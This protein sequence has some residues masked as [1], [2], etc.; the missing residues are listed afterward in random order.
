MGYLCYC[1]ASHIASLQQFGP[2]VLKTNF[3]NMYYENRSLIN[4]YLNCN[5]IEP[6]KHCRS[7][8]KFYLVPKVYL[9]RGN[10]RKPQT[11]KMARSK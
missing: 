4:N 8:Q 3:I 10:K 7:M 6:Y 11:S 2:K 1:P 5:S 9:F